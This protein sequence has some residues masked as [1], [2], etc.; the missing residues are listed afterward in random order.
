MR[1][2][3]FHPLIFYPL[4]LIAAA[5][6]IGV[7]LQPWKWERPPAPVAARQAEQTLVYSRTAFNSPAP[8]AEQHMFVVRDFW[9]RATALRIA[10]LPGQQPPTPADNG[11]RVLMMPDDAARLA[12]RPVTVE[13]S[14]NPSPV[15]AATS[16]A[17]SLRGASQ[18]QW[19]A[20]E[21]PPQPNTVRFDLPA[22]GAVNAIGLRA[23]SADHDQASA[24]EITR[25]RVTPRA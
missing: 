16:L 1:S 14:Y 24:V 17:V 13:V 3:L 7:S 8:S 10:V 23:I 9:G 22:Q 25:I 15:N 2:W 21:I 18:S 5:L 11:V 19:V 12:G 20:H 6:L 4:A